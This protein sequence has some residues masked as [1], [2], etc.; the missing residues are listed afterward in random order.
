LLA[1]VFA[2][3]LLGSDCCA[4][5]AA[6]KVS[7]KTAA[8]RQRIFI[9]SP[10]YGTEQKWACGDNARRTNWFQKLWSAGTERRHP[11]LRCAVIL[12]G[13]VLNKCRQDAC[14]PHA[15]MRA[16]LDSNHFQLRI[17]LFF[18]HTLDR[19][20]RSGQRTWASAAGA[21]IANLQS[22]LGEI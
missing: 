8:K 3:G 1:T 17:D 18:Q 11:C 19:H 9:V 21:L 22:V 14:V 15:R 2:A 7:T 6:Q 16:L 13:F 20:Q 5:I 4:T 12:D 10:V